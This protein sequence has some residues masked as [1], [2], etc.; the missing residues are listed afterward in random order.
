[1]LNSLKNIYKKL[2]SGAALLS[3]LRA[4]DEQIAQLRAAVGAILAEAPGLS[5]AE[6]EAARAKIEALLAYQAI[7]KD[8]TEGL[9]ALYESA[10]TR[11]AAAETVIAELQDRVSAMED[12]LRRRGGRT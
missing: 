5:A 6:K 11:L 12:A 8:E 1:M 7:A 10:A 9:R 2:G 4:H 3:G